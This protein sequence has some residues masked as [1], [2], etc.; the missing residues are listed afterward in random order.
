MSCLCNILCP[1]CCK[2]SKKDKNEK[3][4]L[5]E[6]TTVYTGEE[7]NEIK[8]DIPEKEQISSKPVMLR[9]KARKRAPKASVEDQ[10]IKVSKVNKTLKLSFP[11]LT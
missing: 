3:G 2:S 8:E 5:I 10:I 11:P 6:N 9:G 4:K 7:L 1:C